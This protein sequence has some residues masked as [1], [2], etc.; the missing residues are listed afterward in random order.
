ME[1]LGQNFPLGT[2]QL[3]CLVCAGGAFRTQLSLGNAAVVMPGLRFVKL[4]G[5]LLLDEASAALDSDTKM[6]AQQVSKA[7]FDDRMI[8]TISYR[9]D[10]IIDS[11]LILVM[12]AGKGC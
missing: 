3:L 2:Q 10:T 6:A 4:L 1:P 9:L 5:V 8:V 11:D 12:Y 7:H